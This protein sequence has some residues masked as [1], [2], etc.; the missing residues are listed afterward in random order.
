MVLIL[1]SST[2]GEAEMTV[3]GNIYHANTC[4]TSTSM[5]GLLQ[6]FCEIEAAELMTIQCQL[7]WPAF[8]E[9]NQGNQIVEHHPKYGSITPYISRMWV[10]A[11]T[12]WTQV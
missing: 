11:G 6:L 9:A 5:V 4:K 1:H 8:S 10:Y 12:E 2:D 3:P 7:N